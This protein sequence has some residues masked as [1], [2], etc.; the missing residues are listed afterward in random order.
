MGE[1]MFK[2]PKVFSYENKE[3]QIYIKEM[4]SQFEGC[5][6]YTLSRINS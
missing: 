3:K 1:Y 2:L 4:T 6:G 5:L